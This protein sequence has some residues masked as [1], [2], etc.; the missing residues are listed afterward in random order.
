M[1]PWC[2]G[3]VRPRAILRQ[4]NWKASVKK[5]LPA[6][7]IQRESGALIV[8]TALEDSFDSLSRPI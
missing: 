4:T 3:V 7:M 8:M 5:V 2:C 1:F 6:T